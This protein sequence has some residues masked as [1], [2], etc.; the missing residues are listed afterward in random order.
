[1]ASDSPG[2]RS[3]F[4]T[5]LPPFVQ[6]H[7]HNAWAHNA[8]NQ[9][10]HIP[11]SYRLQWMTTGRL[12]VEVAPTGTGVSGRKNG[13]GNPVLL[14]SP[15]MLSTGRPTF[16]C[17]LGWASFKCSFTC[18]RE[19]SMLITCGMIALGFTTAVDLYFS[20]ANFPYIILFLFGWLFMQNFFQINF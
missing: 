15:C 18:D 9:N 16:S 5:N 3:M 14:P 6:D 4:Q 12:P 8:R 11:I 7:Q 17:F 13:P 10:A 2:I 19:A 20:C 1:M